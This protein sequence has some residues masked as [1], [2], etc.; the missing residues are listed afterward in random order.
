MEVGF[1]TGSKWGLNCKTDGHNFL[2]KHG[3][4]GT[5]RVPFL[6]SEPFN[7]GTIWQQISHVVCKSGFQIEVRAHTLPPRYLVL[8]QVCHHMKT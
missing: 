2:L 3:S 6:E 7:G 1:I 5:W 4:H 8:P